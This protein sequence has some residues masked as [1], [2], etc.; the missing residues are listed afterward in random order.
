MKPLIE[1]LTA[2][3]EKSI[4]IEE[5]CN[6]RLVCKHTHF[7]V[8]ESDEN[9]DD[10]MKDDRLTKD[11]SKYFH[12]YAGGQSGYETIIDMEQPYVIHPESSAIEVKDI[13]DNVIW[14]VFFERKQIDVTKE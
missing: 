1:L 8:G 13:D 10:D 6:G 3:Y 2:L 14:L 11:G 9:L 7:G 12:L 5:F 4:M